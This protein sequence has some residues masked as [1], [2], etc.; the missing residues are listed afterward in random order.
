M[1]HGGGLISAL[2]DADIDGD[3]LDE[4]DIVANLIL[5]MVGAQETT[6]NLIGTGLLT[7]LRHPDALRTLCERPELMPS[8][9]EELLRFES[10]SQYTARIAPVDTRL[11]DHDIRAGQGVIALIGAA[12][13]DPERFRDPDVLDISRA[14]NRHLAFGWGS[15]FCFGAPLAP[16]TLAWRSNVGLRGLTALPVRGTA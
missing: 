13:R 9:V 6:A 5:T 11:G 12:N 2:A 8:A 15:H 7:L 10:P 14:D 3:H 1:R 4:D 16:V